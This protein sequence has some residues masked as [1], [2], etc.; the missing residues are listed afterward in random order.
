MSW[1]HSISDWT[2]R[3]GHF[4]FPIILR[5]HSYQ[6]LLL[7][8]NTLC[9]D[10]FIGCARKTTP[11]RVS[12]KKLNGTVLLSASRFGWFQRRNIRSQ[13]AL[14]RVLQLYSKWDKNQ[15]IPCFGQFAARM[16]NAVKHRRLSLMGFILLL[17]LGWVAFFVVVLKHIW[18]GSQTDL[19]LMLVKIQNVH[20][21]TLLYYH[22]CNAATF[23]YHQTQGQL[24]L[25]Y[26]PDNIPYQCMF[27][28]FIY[29][30][31][32]WRD[33]RSGVLSTQWTAH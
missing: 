12:R 4:R 16:V 13:S 27:Q 22:Q 31:C 26:D 15:K 19:W 3:R 32:L 33:S 11:V 5:I 18:N 30:L 8:I 9:A 23:N 7:P 25:G 1:V 6:H 14:G 29:T 28:W 10:A 2:Q 20:P 17:L 21:G 24:Q